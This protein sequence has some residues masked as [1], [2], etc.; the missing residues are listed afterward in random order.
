MIRPQ[1][2]GNELIAE[3]NILLGS[4]RKYGETDEVG[5]RRFEA[6]AK[7]LLKVNAVEGH[8]VLSM[9]YQL[10]GDL[11]RAIEHIDAALD[12]TSAALL[13]CNKAAIL[14]N[15]GKFLEAQQWFA[16]GAKPE[17]GEFTNRWRVGTCSGSWHMLEEF[18]SAANRLALDLT[19]VDQELIGRVTRVMDESS[20][21]DRDLGRIQDVAGSMLRQEE[22]FFIGAGPEVFVWDQDA[23]EKHISITFR[24]PVTARRAI[25]LDRELGHRLFDEIPDLPFAIMLHFESGLPSNERFAERSAEAR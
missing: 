4:A 3:L 16:S 22:M 24:L 5:L 6:K 2:T 23:L 11:G 20:I 8:N 19:N 14:T 7:Q 15:F 25:E 9:L 17:R 12:L 10:K 18:C 21:T 1:T 13:E